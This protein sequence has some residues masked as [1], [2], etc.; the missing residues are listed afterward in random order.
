MNKFDLCQLSLNKTAKDTAGKLQYHER[1]RE[2][3]RERERGGRER[4]RK[5]EREEREEKKKKRKRIQ[6]NSWGCNSVVEYLPG[7]H[8]ALGWMGVQRSVTL[9]CCPTQIHVSTS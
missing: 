8:E 6:L 3:G 1:D 5:R 2:R 9:A 4:Q 7:M